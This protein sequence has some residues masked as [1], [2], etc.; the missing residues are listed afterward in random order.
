M[1][2]LYLIYNLDK[3]CVLSVHLWNSV[4]MLIVL[5]QVY[6][7]Y[8]NATATTIFNNLNSIS[9]SSALSIDNLNTTSTSLLGS[10]G[11]HSTKFSVLKATSTTLL[12]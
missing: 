3:K 7:K 8:L 2:I 9:T 5:R 1:L 11:A 10:R 4:M 6:I 12:G